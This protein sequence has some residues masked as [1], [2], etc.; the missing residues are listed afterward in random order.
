MTD[1][2]CEAYGPR[3]GLFSDECFMSNGVDLFACSQ[4]HQCA[5]RMRVERQR[6][7]QAIQR[8]A[9]TDVQWADLAREIPHPEMIL[10]GSLR[11][12]EDRWEEEGPQ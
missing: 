6:V 9:A 12:Q 4:P 3:S 1:F 5:V 8:L 2:E 10:G 7:W 11:P